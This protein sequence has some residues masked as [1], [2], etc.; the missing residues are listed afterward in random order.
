MPAGRETIAAGRQGSH[1]LAGEIRRDVGTLAS[2]VASGSK[3]SLGSSKALVK[4]SSH[5]V[6]HPL[7]PFFSH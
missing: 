3:S 6:P 5:T 1:Q 4:R 2:V 7:S